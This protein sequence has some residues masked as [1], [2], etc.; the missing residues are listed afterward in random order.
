MRKLTS[1]GVYSD[2][3]VSRQV[4]LHVEAQQS[5]RP[6][7]AASPPQSRMQD[8]ISHIERPQQQQQQQQQLQQQQQQRHQQRVDTS[9]SAS[10]TGSLAHSIAVAEQVRSSSHRRYTDTPQHPR[11]AQVRHFSIS[12]LHVVSVSGYAVY[13]QVIMLYSE[14]CNV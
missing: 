4:P 8:S 14:A 2:H 7:E 12:S 5:Q 3:C 6:E 11:A 10:T 1:M 13:C 9:P